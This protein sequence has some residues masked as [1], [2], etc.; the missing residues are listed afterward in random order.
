MSTLCRIP[1]VYKVK[2]SENIYGKA[3]KVSDAGLSL[4]VRTGKGVYSVGICRN[5][6][7]NV[8]N[9]Y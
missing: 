2:C 7:E 4:W 6:R 8:K 3:D 5:M 1:T 9:L